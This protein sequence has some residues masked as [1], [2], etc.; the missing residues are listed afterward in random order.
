MMRVHHI[1][2]AVHVSAA[3]NDDQGER[4]GLRQQMIVIQ[5][6]LAGSRGEEERGPTE[7]GP[8]GGKKGPD[9]EEG[10]DRAQITLDL[11][12][13]R[14]HFLEELIPPAA[15]K[16]G[17]DAEQQAGGEQQDAVLDERRLRDRKSTRLN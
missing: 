6:S 3:E 13:R 15:D 9:A 8:V 4:P 5:I 12:G 17:V 7:D 1:E 11:G 2:V 14:I 10:R 16:M